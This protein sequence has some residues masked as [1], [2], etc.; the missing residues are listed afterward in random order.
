M[1]Y[2]EGADDA[3]MEYVMGGQP[4]D[5]LALE[6]DAAGGRPEEARD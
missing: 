4:V 3:A 5:A 2:L 1:W 6:K